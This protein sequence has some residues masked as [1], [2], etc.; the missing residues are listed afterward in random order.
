L[1][2]RLTNPFTA[3]FLNKS[4]RPDVVVGHPGWGDMLPMLILFVL[5]Q[6]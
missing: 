4:L 2:C 3:D 6:R 1:V 5:L